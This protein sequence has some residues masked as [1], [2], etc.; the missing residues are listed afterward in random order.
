MIQCR[1]SDDGI[2]HS[3]GLSLGLFHKITLILYLGNSSVNYS[4]G[5][6]T[7]GIYSMPKTSLKWTLEY[8]H[9]GEELRNMV[10]YV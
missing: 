9:N 2:K 5:R 1:I 10:F 4:Q 3:T 6:C 8:L 7:E